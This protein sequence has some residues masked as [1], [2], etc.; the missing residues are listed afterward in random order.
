VS[1]AV[2][3]AAQRVHRLPL[4]EVLERWRPGSHDCDWPDE[5]GRIALHD[6]PQL[7]ALMFDMLR[8][9]AEDVQPVVLGWDGRVWAG[10][11]RLYVWWWLGRETVPVD[12]VDD[13]DTR[14]GWAGHCAPENLQGAT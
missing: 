10:H 2:E 13:G 5:F 8:H 14:A 4:G 11:R 9:G 3:A 1:A 12:I 7:V 6:S